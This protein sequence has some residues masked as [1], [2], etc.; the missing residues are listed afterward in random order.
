MTADNKNRSYNDQPN[1]F[2]P[3]ELELKENSSVTV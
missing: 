1:Y 3:L 2:L